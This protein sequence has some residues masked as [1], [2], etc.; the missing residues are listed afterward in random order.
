[1]SSSIQIADVR[2]V[3]IRK[4][5]YGLRQHWKSEKENLSK[6]NQRSKAPLDLKRGRRGVVAGPCAML[7]FSGT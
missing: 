5:S 6:E 3:N 4:G 1:M 2:S 7:W